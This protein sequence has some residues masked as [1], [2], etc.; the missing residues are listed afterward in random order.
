MLGPTVSHS[1]G[2]DNAEACISLEYIYFKLALS[3]K[4][5]DTTPLAESFQIIKFS[6]GVASLPHILKIALN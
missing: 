4:G 1:I 3:K 5:G 2:V 6:V